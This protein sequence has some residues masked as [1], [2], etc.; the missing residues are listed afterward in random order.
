MNAQI[1][2]L[3]LVSALALGLTGCASTAPVEEAAVTVHAGGSETD[4]G[5]LPAAARIDDVDLPGIANLDAD[6]RA[7]VREAAAEALEDG[8]VFT[9]N[10][11]WRSASYQ[12][13]LLDDA[14]STYGSRTEAAR[15]VATPESSP[16]VTGDAVD[17][18]PVDASSWLSQHGSAY[19]LCQ[20]YGNE[21]WHY[22]LR[23][24][25]ATSGCPQQYADPTEDPRMRR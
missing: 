19:G 16:H 11:G 25:A 15:W 6:L 24:D 22:E 13:G 14:V 12:Q 4:G 9:V 5:A 10:S 17:I 23:P 21:I 18:G 2:T 20:I 3:T 1:I 8:V 7:A